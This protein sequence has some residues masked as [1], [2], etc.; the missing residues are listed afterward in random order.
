MENIYSCP[1]DWN[2]RIIGDI[3][4]SD[5]DYQFDTRIFLLDLET[6][7]IYTARDSGCSCPTPFETILTMDDLSEVTDIS[8]Y[9]EEINEDVNYNSGTDIEEAQN[10]IRYIDT[11]LQKN[12]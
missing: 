12:K 5:G 9:R 2:M 6:N 10:A 8:F 4:F 1:E 7:K 11:L 3:E